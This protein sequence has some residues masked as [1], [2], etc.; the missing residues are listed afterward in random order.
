MTE[1]LIVP[2]SGMRKGIK[3]EVTRLTGSEA[4]DADAWKW[5][6]D[7]NNTH[8]VRQLAGAF[9][10]QIRKQNRRVATA[11]REA[12]ASEM[13]YRKAQAERKD[14]AIREYLSGHGHHFDPD[15]L[16]KAGVPERALNLTSRAVTASGSWKLVTT[17]GT[18]SF[19]R[20]E[21]FETIEGR[22]WV[23]QN[24]DL[25]RVIRKM[26]QEFCNNGQSWESKKAE[27]D[28]RLYADLTGAIQ[29]YASDLRASWDKELLDSTFSVDGQEVR[30]GSATKEQHRARIEWLTSHAQGTVETAAMHEV[31]IRDIELNGVGSLDD[32]LGDSDD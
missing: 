28:A 3:Q 1:T 11:A 9:I 5:I 12:K 8:A 25:M 29:Q 6:N 17:E 4:T 19:T 16:I 23:E 22:E 13:A 31:A 7:P 30:W 2:L 24:P 20:D 26:K 14:K 27:M 32:V 15:A 18:V 10:L 21:W